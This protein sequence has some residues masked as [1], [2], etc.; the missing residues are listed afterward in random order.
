[1]L[2]FANNTDKSTQLLFP[3]D[4]IAQ[5]HSNIVHVLA[6]TLLYINE[7]RTLNGLL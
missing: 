3:L 6:P 7:D 4:V 5:Q 1:M 2:Y